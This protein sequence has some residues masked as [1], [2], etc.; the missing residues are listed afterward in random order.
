MKEFVIRPVSSGD[1]YS[2]KKHG[3]IG[4]NGHRTIGA[5]WMSPIGPIGAIRLE[6]GRQSIGADGRPIAPIEVLTTPD[7]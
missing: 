5:Y 6:F 3:S 4:R 2:F 7:R 1:D